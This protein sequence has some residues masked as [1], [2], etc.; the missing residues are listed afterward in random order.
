[1]PKR[2]S[3]DHI[4]EAVREHGSFGAAARALGMDRRNLA[5][6][7][8]R[9]ATYQDRMA[10]EAGRADVDPGVVE[11]ATETGLSLDTARHGWRRIQREDGGFDSVFW[12]NPQDD[13]HDALHEAA[14][15]MVEAIEPLKP[16]SAPVPRNA[17]LLNLFPLTDA[18]I[19][20]LAWNEETD[21][22][23][24]TDI[25]ERVLVGWF[26]EAIDRAPESDIA[27]LAQL[28]D[29]LHTDALEP[30]TP[31]SK[32]VLDA[33]S[34]YPRIVR[35]VIRVIRQI[36]DMLL[37]RYQSVHVVWCEGNHDPT[38]SIW[39]REMLAALYAD[40]P[41]LHVDCSPKPFHCVEH[42]N[43]SLFFHHGHLVKHE[44][45]DRVMAAEFRD[46]FGR[47]NHSYAH[48]GHLHHKAVK[49]S[50]L[51]IVEQHRTLASR[52]AHAA[53]HGYKA[54]TDASCIT[55]H[56]THGEVG[57]VTI[58]RAMIDSRSA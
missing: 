22:D 52:D 7:F 48:M 27:V 46:V 16:A 21:S 30:L 50:Q 44:A 53:R 40:E 49:E 39:C 9:S 2:Q 45:L 43:T 20:A 37:A 47:T 8:K 34:R 31:A 18:H 55:Y 19:G 33:D 51:M 29:L 35:M 15:A 17:D 1:M 14:A 56:A 57:R 5:R 28:G 3:D 6:R 54:G 38:G 10:M 58:S 23:W 24:D 25:A 4:I 12:R 42:G 26:G 41:R 32:N 13:A 36:V 11:A